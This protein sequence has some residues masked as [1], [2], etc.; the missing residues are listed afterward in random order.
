MKLLIDLKVGQRV[1]EDGHRYSY[2]YERNCRNICPSTYYQTVSYYSTSKKHGGDS[3]AGLSILSENL[4][5]FIVLRG[6]N[7]HLTKERRDGLYLRIEYMALRLNPWSTESSTSHRDA[8]DTPANQSDRL[9][10]T[11]PGGRV[12]AKYDITH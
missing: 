8:G 1:G 2:S 10:P 11:E 7:R 5:M 9:S 4:R 3:D 12:E 6:N